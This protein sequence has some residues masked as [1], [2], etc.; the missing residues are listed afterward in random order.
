VCI[1]AE[2]N[3]IIIAG[4]FRAKGCTLYVTTYPCLLCAKMIAQAGI[5]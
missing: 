1:H 2:E 5:T 4:R 3:A